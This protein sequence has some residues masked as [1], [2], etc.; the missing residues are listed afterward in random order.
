MSDF[1][2]DYHVVSLSGWYYGK[3][4][5]LLGNF[6]YE[7]HNDLMTPNGAVEKRMRRF[8]NAWEVDNSCKSTQTYIDRVPA[9][10]TDE[11][12]AVFDSS[13]SNLRPCFLAVRLNSK[14]MKWVKVIVCEKSVHVISITVITSSHHRANITMGTFSLLFLFHVI[15]QTF[16]IRSIHIVE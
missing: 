12:Q 8:L 4:G 10:S 15:I 7:T 1:S 3:V 9:K 11:C 16:S 5:G 14:F 6:D 2:R 13:S